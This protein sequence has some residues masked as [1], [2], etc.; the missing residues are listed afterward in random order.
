[1]KKGSNVIHL[2]TNSC[3]YERVRTTNRTNKAG[4]AAGIP[5]LGSLAKIDV[6]DLTWTNRQTDILGE[7]ANVRVAEGCS[8]TISKA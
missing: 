6:K 2:Q 4:F 7:I 1:M 5:D 8:N 3:H